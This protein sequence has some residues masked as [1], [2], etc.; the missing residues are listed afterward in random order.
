MVSPEEA[1][2][3]EMFRSGGHATPEYAADYYG[4]PWPMAAP[5]T[6]AFGKYRESLRHRADLSDGTVPRYELEGFMLRARALPRKWM[7]ARLGMTTASL[8]NLLGK[9]DD[10]GMATSRYQVYGEFVAEALSEDLVRY[11]PGLR[12]RTFSD[13]D[14]Y[15]A[16]LHEEVRRAGVAVEELWCETSLRIGE[17]P[18]RYAMHFDCLTLQPLSTMHSAW[19]DFRKP[20]RLPPDRCSKLFY[21]ENADELRPW[22]A[23]SAEPDDLDQYRQFLAGTHHG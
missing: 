4:L 3:L 1:Q 2:R 13:H 23:G 6:A 20:L 8:E 10:F 16:R 19:L 5:A 15:C 14:S 9:L 22:V 18:R 21:V 17:F 7:A 12:F 11:L